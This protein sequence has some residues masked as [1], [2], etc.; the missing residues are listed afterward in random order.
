MPL[1]QGIDEIVTVTDCPGERVPV[2]GL[3]LAPER[4]LLAVQFTL[5]CE[6]EDSLRFNVH[7]EAFCVPP[8]IALFNV[9]GVTVKVGGVQLQVTGTGVSPSLPE[10]VKVPLWHGI[11]S[12]VTETDPPGLKLPEDGVKVTPLRRVL[13]DQLALS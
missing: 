5:P 8:H 12:M 1:W 3:R 6:F 4:S 2:A 10:K 11:E 9:V 13:A 7:W